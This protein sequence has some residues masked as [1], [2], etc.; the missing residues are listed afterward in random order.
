[1]NASEQGLTEDDFGYASAFI[2]LKLLDNNCIK[3]E[4]HGSSKLPEKGDFVKSI[5]SEFGNK[6]HMSHENFEALITKLKLGGENADITEDHSSHDHR[7]RRSVHDDTEST[8]L[9][10]VNIVNLVVLLGCFLKY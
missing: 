3:H 7:R 6:S 5:L 9:H 10:K 4:E 2:I 1:M 8:N